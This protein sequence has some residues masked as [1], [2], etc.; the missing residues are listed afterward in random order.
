M[1]DKHLPSRQG[2]LYC[3]RAWKDGIV[4]E[5]CHTVWGQRQWGLEKEVEMYVTLLR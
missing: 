2:M 1:S 4:A 3:S 5:V